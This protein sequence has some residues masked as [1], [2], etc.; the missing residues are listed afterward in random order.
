MGDELEFTSSEKSLYQDTE[1][2]RSRSPRSHESLS[3]IY[4]P[5]QERCIMKKVKPLILLVAE[6]GYQQQGLST[7]LEA[8]P[9]V[10]VVVT[11]APSSA[12]TIVKRCSPSA[13]LV[14]S[15]V[16]ISDRKTIRKT[17]DDF[18]SKAPFV[19]L[20]DRVSDNGSKDTSPD[21]ADD[22][23]SKEKSVSELI[24][25]V[26]KVIESHKL[27]DRRVC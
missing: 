19:L 4:I 24:E 11:Y 5:S 18:Q 26:R 13:V 22:V 1:R 25:E 3:T 9:E 15:S 20:A 27:S 8:I 23:I 17:V 10:D 14:D 12:C 16:S 7:W 6:P 2:I 21:I